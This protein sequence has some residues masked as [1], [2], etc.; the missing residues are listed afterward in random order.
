MSVSLIVVFEF[1]NVCGVITAI[2]DIAEVLDRVTDRK[3]SG[4]L[5]VSGVPHMP[6]RRWQQ[7]EE[8]PPRKTHQITGIDNDAKSQSENY[9]GATPLVQRASDFNYRIE[10]NSTRQR[11]KLGSANEYSVLEIGIICKIAPKHMSL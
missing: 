1:R 6:M 7:K 2:H 9:T 8:C 5:C 11:G 3:R 10:T 4:T